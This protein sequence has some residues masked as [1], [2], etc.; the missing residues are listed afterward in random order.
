MLPALS[1]GHKDHLDRIGSLAE[2]HEVIT[3]VE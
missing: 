2:R 3:H 1:V